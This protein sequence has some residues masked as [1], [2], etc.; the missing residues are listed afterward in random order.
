MLTFDE[1]AHCVA[2]ALSDKR[3]RSGFVPFLLILTRKAVICLT[4]GGL[5]DYIFAGLIT[6]WCDSD[7]IQMDSERK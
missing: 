2:E 3:G 5:F 4:S 6:G 1:L 7:K